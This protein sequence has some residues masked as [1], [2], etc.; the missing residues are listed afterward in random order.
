[1][2]K[3]HLK[4]RLAYWFD[5]MMSKGAI[6][7]IKLLFVITLVIAILV[8]AIA[9]CVDGPRTGHLFGYYIWGSF[10]RILD[11]GNL[12]GDNEA[13]NIFYIV[14]M[15]LG[16]SPILSVKSSAWL[17]RHCHPSFDLDHP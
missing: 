2:K 7:L 16:S 13:G 17:K 4:Q 12:A 14:L 8:A 5:N 3:P 1:M 15:I 9:F 11:A 6:S 10:M